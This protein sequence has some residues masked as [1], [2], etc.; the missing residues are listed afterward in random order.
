MVSEY[1]LGEATQA[2]A[3]VGVRVSAGGWVGR[4][5]FLGRKRPKGGG[6]RGG[7]V[8]E[9]RIKVQKKKGKKIEKKKKKVSVKIGISLWCL[10]FI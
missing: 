5:V 8:Q 1:V 3:C 4:C 2:S 9:E 7:K 10:I 6:E